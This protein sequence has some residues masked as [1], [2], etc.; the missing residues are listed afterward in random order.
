MNSTKPM[1]IRDFLSHDWE[2][3]GYIQNKIMKEVGIA[4]SEY[5]LK[6]LFLTMTCVA[7]EGNQV[8]LLLPS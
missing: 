2:S 3:I 1:Q 7:V 8:R 5:R 6:H 4:I